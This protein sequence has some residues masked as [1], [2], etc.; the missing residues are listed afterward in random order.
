MCSN[1]SPESPY[2]STIMDLL[3]LQKPSGIIWAPQSI[4]L[5]PL[6]LWVPLFLYV[7]LKIDMLSHCSCFPMK[8][9]INKQQQNISLVVSF[10]SDHCSQ[11][12]ALSPPPTP[13]NLMLI[14]PHIVL[15]T[16]CHTPQLLWWQRVTAQHSKQLRKDW[17]W[18]LSLG[19]PPCSFRALPC[20]RQY[21]T[22]DMSG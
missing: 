4:Y 10:V 5:L 7:F 6:P 9:K 11:P 18:S 12:L 3:L 21:W 1:V 16:K 17:T 2:L 22:V 13:F 8:K 14:S 20:M 19:I 15:P